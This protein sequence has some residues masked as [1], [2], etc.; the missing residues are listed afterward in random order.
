MNLCVIY[1]C[2]IIITVKFVQCGDKYPYQPSGGDDT[3]ED[4]DNN[5]D[6]IV[7]E[8][9]SLV[10]EDDET[11]GDTVVSDNLMQHGLGHITGQGYTQPGEY[12]NLQPEQP[13][14]YYPGY[15]PTPPQSFENYEPKDQVI[16][17]PSI[18]I[19]PVTQPLT[20]NEGQKEQPIIP[21]LPFISIL[22]YDQQK[23]I[24]PVTEKDILLV[25]NN[26]T[27]T[28]VRLN[29]KC[30]KIYHNETIVWEH[31]YEFKHPIILIFK[32]RRQIYNLTFKDKILSMIYNGVKWKIKIFYIPTNLKFYI[33][34]YMGNLVKVRDN[35]YTVELVGPGVF[36]FRIEG[37]VYLSA[38]KY[39]DEIIWEREP[40]TPLLRVVTHSVD[41]N[42]IRLYLPQII[43]ETKYDEDKWTHKIVYRK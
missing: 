33:K 37:N 31:K 41:E 4:E 5:F 16:Q 11:P 2:I 24:V 30:N 14:Q 27:L 25:M 12:V 7:R 23:N 17:K 19:P 10:T 26:P 42:V 32:K 39:D 28:M 9:E 38:I 8:L 43:I 3:E 36:K 15:K 29:C 21:E 34:N 40:N 13:T 1:T 6:V 22:K 35:K 18:H 20:G